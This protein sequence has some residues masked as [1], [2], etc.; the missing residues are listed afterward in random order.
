MTM[1]PE[2]LAALRASIKHWEQ[3]R[4]V[5]EPIFAGIQAKDCPLCD[6]FLD[7]HRF[8]AESFVRDYCG[9][10]PIAKKTGQPGCEGTPW[11]ATRQALS[12][13][14]CNPGN[15]FYRHRWRVVAQREVDF[16]ISLLPEGE[17]KCA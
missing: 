5:R 2:T 11:M 14:S 4:D 12:T 17:S 15:A 6:V 13:W 16:L 8:K 7:R 9:A 10:C 3:N 1:A